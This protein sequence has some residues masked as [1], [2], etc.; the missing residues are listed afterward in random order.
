MSWDKE[1]L[2]VCGSGLL[3]VAMV[4]GA[5]IVSATR[6]GAA[7]KDYR[8]DILK[9]YEINANRT[10]IEAAHLCKK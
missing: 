1:L 10:A 4:I 6:Q 3:F 2:T 9:C 5:M 8:A 7:D